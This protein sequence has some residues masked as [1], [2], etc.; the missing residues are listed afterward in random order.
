MPQR[1]LSEVYSICATKRASSY[2]DI[3]TS[4]VYGTSNKD[5]KD[6]NQ[7]ILSSQM[8]WDLGYDGN[9]EHDPSEKAGAYHVLNNI[10][11]HSVVRN[12]NNNVLTFARILALHY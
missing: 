6:L 1:A 5:I 9:T 2:L 8:V 3:T 10:D 4:E 11:I 12:I 7:T